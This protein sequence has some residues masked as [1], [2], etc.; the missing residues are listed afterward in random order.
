MA[1][2]VVVFVSRGLAGVSRIGG[3]TEL[4]ITF[5]GSEVFEPLDDVFAGVVV[6]ENPVQAGH[7]GPADLQ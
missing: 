5:G 6:A 3:C 2:L 7:Q 1:L 4:H